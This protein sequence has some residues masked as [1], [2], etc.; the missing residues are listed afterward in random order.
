MLLP[1]S[2]GAI[3]I[4]THLVPA[5]VVFIFLPLIGIFLLVVV[6]HTAAI[7]AIVIRLAVARVLVVAIV[8]VLVARVFLVMPLL[9]VMLLL[10]VL[11]AT[12]LVDVIVNLI[13]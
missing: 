9:K 11:V 7:V 2:R 12:L 4:A 5:P 8:P 3:S 10:L 13:A 6:R 1:F